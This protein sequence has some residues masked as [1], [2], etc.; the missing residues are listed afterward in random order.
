MAIHAR[1]TVGKPLVQGKKENE[2]R[3][4]AAAAKAAEQAPE[5]DLG[6]DLIMLKQV[7]RQEVPKVRNVKSKEQA[8]PKK[9]SSKV[10]P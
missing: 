4:L 7:I 3:R 1:Y 9:T 10:N 8:N 2:A 6:L 5:K